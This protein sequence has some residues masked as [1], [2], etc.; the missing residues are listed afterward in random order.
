MRSALTACAVPATACA[1]PVPVGVLSL[2]TD[3]LPGHT[4]LSTFLV[5]EQTKNPENTEKRA[6]QLNIRDQAHTPLRFLAPGA[7]SHLDSVAFLAFYRS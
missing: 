6:S 1:V 3:Q 2:T 5:N 7:S 4:D